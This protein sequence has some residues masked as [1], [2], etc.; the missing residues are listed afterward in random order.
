MT[1]YSG[2]SPEELAKLI[3]NTGNAKKFINDLNYES[4][5]NYL[6]N[7]QQEVLV[8]L[9]SSQKRITLER[10][11]EL[12]I[13]AKLSPD[14]RIKMRIRLEQITKNKQDTNNGLKT[15]SNEL[16]SLKEVVG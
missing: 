10:L 1:L 12:F 6:T 7:V 4:Y 11:K 5:N 16:A 13:S 15:I 3:M 9:V 2:V 14:Q 8:E